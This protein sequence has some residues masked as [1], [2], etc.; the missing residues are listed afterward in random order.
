MSSQSNS[1]PSITIVDEVIPAGIAQAANE[2]DLLQ[3]LLE[4]LQQPTLQLDLQ[5][6]VVYA[7]KAALSLFASTTEMLVS[8]QLHSFLAAP[9]SAFY[10]NCFEQ[11][12]DPQALVHSASEMMIDINETAVPV[13]MSLSFMPVKQPCLLATFQD[14]RAQKAEIQRLHQLACTDALTGL[15]N[16]RAFFETLQKLWEQCTATR[17]PISIV[18]VDVDHFKL[19]NDRFGHIQGDRCLQQVAYAL[20][21]ALPDEDCLAARYGGEE[22]AL[23]LP[24]MNGVQAKTIAEGLRERISQIN[25]GELAGKSGITVSQGIAAEVN[26]QFRTPEALLFAAD[27]ALYRA[28][29]DGRDRVNLSN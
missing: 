3:L 19:F 23:I 21:Q 20:Q 17:D 4:R 24:G 2:V 7:N 28:K 26:G 29:K 12:G 10:R 6:S 9:W 15:A 5:G 18:I 27:T 25:C 22:F 11:Y 16:R 14:L 8:K 1:K 13:N